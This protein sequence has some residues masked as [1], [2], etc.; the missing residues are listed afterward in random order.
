[1]A[2]ALRN[3]PA[4]RFER[5]ALAG[6][7]I[8]TRYPWHKTAGKITVRNYVATA[9]YVVGIFPHF[10]ELLRANASDT[11]GAGSLGFDGDDSV[12]N[13]QVAYV[14]GGHGA[15]LSPG[16]TPNMLSFIVRAQN[17]TPISPASKATFQSGPAVWA[18]RLCWLVWIL[19]L[20]VVNGDAWLTLRVTKTKNWVVRLFALTIYV[21]VVIALLNTV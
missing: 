10:C 12:R 4:C 11:G 1:L 19:L 16:V 20:S 18:S 3:Y 2:Q 13:E 8:P 5:A 14:I 6:S 17:E 7:V 21:L 9:D 15:A